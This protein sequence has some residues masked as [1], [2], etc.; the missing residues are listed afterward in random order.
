MRTRRIVVAA[1][2]AVALLALVVGVPAML[3][4]AVGNPLPNG[5]VLKSGNLDDSAVLHLLACVVWIA[6]LQWIPGTVLEIAAAVRG[7]SLPRHISAGQGLSRV[8]ITAVIG[9][10][11]AAPLVGNTAKAWATPPPPSATPAP[12]V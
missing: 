8:L 5:S 9:V 7:V 12:V 2:A 4:G 6:W 11:I 1:L 10:A 3:L